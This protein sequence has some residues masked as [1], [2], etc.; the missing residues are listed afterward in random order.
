MCAR[1]WCA[2]TA[3]TA[4]RWRLG[5][6]EVLRLSEGEARGGGAQRAVDPRRCARGGHRRDL[7]RRRLR[8]ARR[9][10]SSGCSARSSPPPT[11][12]AGPRMP[13]TELQEWLQARRL[14]VPV[15]RIAATRG[16]A[17]AQTF[18][19]ECGV[20]ALG[21]V[22][23]ARGNRAAQAEQ[24]AARRMLDNLKTQRR[25][26]R[27]AAV[28]SADDDFVQPPAPM[29]VA[30]PTRATPCRSAAAWSPSSAGP[31]S[32][33]RRCSTRWSA[34]RSASPPTRR[35]PRGTASPA[36]APSGRASSS[37]STRPA[38]RRATARRSNRTL[39]R[40]VQGALADVD[41]VLFVVEAGRFGTDDAKVLALLQ[42]PSSAA[43]AA[44]PAGAAGRQQA[45]RGAA[46]A[47]TSR[48]GCRRCRRATPSPSS[49]R[50][51]R[52]ARPTSSGC[53]SIVEPYLPEQPWLLRGR[54]AD[55]PQRAL[56]GQRADPR[57]AVPPDGR[58]AALHLDGGD[59]PLRGGEPPQAR[60]GASC[61]SPPSIVVER[62]AP[63][64]HGHRRPAASA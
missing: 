16:Q 25:A 27:A 55:R 50:C 31:T 60:A 54:R 47:P 11:C 52:A 44:R 59:R 35:R 9:R 48:P 45:R 23:R 57:E 26:G 38:S 12:E 6:P 22:S 3:C 64:G 39:N 37:S 14:P 49:C 46:R 30:V 13:K 4:R 8:A 56:P 1:T 51:R 24:E 32:A 42:L 7:P 62:D 29:P 20:P 15:Y 40:T 33:S 28:M 19:V 43:K 36:S 21:L 5:L 17:H 61:A 41:V 58:R 63:Q 2:R 53:S 34:R 18:E 10:S